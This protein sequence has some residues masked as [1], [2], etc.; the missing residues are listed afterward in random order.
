MVHNQNCDL[1]TWSKS[2][3]FVIRN[4]IIT[5]HSTKGWAK[6]KKKLCCTPRRVN[7][8]GLISTLVYWDQMENFQGKYF[9]QTSKKAGAL[10][11]SCWEDYIFEGCLQYYQKL[12][13]RW[14]PNTL[15]QT[16]K[17]LPLKTLY[18]S[19]TFKVQKTPST[20]VL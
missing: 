15:T 18:C 16:Q 1:A 11:A 6:K 12:K 5:G 19:E 3:F 4:H 9:Q 7:Q 8:H 13:S 2:C 20:N 17:Y 14:K 10:Y